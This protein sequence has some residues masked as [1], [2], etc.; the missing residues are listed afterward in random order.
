M[1]VSSVAT[2][3]A[4]GAASSVNVNLVKD[5]QNLEVDVVDRLLSA[6]GIGT[7]VSAAG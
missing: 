1:D 3:A 2:T 4:A 5:T 7:N 6:L